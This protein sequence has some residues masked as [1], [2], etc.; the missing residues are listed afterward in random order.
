M[1]VHLLRIQ[2]RPDCPN[3][4]FVTNYYRNI[5]N[6]ISYKGDCGVD[7]IFPD[8][9][10]FSTN[11]VTKCNMGIACEFIPNACLYPESTEFGPFM[12][13]PRSSIV[14]T[15]LTLANS[16]GIFDPEYRGAVIAALRCNIDRDHKSTIDEFE[17]S[18]KKGTRLVQIIAPD[19]KPI[20]IELVEK[21]TETNRGANGFG[22]TNNK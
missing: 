15:P 21:L 16:I 12:L 11:T 17:Y 3:E 8:D 13:V 20:K 5:V 22:S 19:M 6:K 10:T 1:S 9:V 4:E 18:V 2:I 14:A 7:I